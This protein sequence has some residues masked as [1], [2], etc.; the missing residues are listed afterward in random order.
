MW[1]FRVKEFYRLKIEMGRYWAPTQIEQQELLSIRQNTI[2]Q[3]KQYY[4][5]IKKK[6]KRYCIAVNRL[7][8]I[9]TSTMTSLLPSRLPSLS[10]TKKYTAAM[11]KQY[12]L[13]L[14]GSPQDDDGAACLF[15]SSHGLRIQGKEGTRH[16]QVEHE[17]L[18][19]IF[20]FEQ[21]ITVSYFSF[22]LSV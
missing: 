8:T 21:T 2:A 22:S 4:A 12:S 5:F 3:I 10:S 9:P 11:N 1:Y 14:D 7:N 6:K 19:C 13:L 18:D 17:H 15:Y 20:K 16:R